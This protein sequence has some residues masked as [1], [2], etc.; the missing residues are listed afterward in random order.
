[1]SR[2]L[3]GDADLSLEQAD[4][5]NRFFGHTADES[6]FFLLLLEKNRAGTTSL[7]AHF[8]REISHLAEERERVNMEKRPKAQ[9]LLSLEDQLKYYSSWQYSAI[10]IALSVPRFQTRPALAQELKIPIETVSQILVFLL[11]T[12]MAQEKNG[13][14]T[15]GKTWIHLPPA[16]ALVAKAHANWRL[17]A[18]ESA[19]RFRR[20]DFHYTQVVSLSE[21]DA[22]RL[23]EFIGTL[24]DQSN[25]I[26]RD[27]KEETLRCL[28]V[29]FF[30]V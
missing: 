17:R 13:R 21:D 24:V 8:D 16:S 20:E 14:Y 4:A 9:E 22:K 7:R 6:R 26:I 10:H 11:R 3:N 1:L 15:I 29:D 12:G 5:A 27:S 2:V 23:T 30:S 28:T 19:E 18:I 25:Q